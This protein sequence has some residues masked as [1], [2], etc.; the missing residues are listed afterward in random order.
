MGVP[1]LRMRRS[2]ATPLPPAR[3]LTDEFTLRQ[4]SVED[5]PN[6][7]QVL[8]DAFG[9]TWT[10][11]RVLSTLLENPG[12]PAT[13]LVLRGERIAA[14]T[15]IQIQP[16]FPDAAFLHWVGVT[17]E[18]RGHGLGYILCHRAL[19]VVR[20]RGFATCF[21]TTDDHRLPAIATYFRLGFEPDPHHDSH[22]E[23]W[24]QIRSELEAQR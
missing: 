2:M 10:R 1:Q 22:P 18:A 20:E 15:S 24:R 14:C 3:L 5:A 11:E 4:A 21:L 13:F 23:R 16:G 7:A 12:V 17:S 19:A 8:T 9:E 6:V